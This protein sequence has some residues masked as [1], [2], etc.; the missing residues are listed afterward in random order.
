MK[1]DKIFNYL[2]LV[3]LTIV[4]SF[5]LMFIFVYVFDDRG[6]GMA[7][8][9]CGGLLVGNLTLLLFLK[10]SLIKLLVHSV[11]YCL[12]LFFLFYAFS[13][14]TLDSS[15]SVKL[16]IQVLILVLLMIVSFEFALMITDR[17][18]RKN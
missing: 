14:F 7:W 9:L 8:G 15:F 17:L 3:S 16:P 4:T 12:F 13:N 10:F 18:G 6:K 1:M 11:I 5:I 2:L